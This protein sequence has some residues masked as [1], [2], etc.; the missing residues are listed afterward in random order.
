MWIFAIVLGIILYIPI[1]VALG[2]LLFRRIMKEREEDGGEVV[3]ENENFLWKKFFVWS[4]VRNK[5]DK[6]NF[7]E[8]FFDAGRGNV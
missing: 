3:N 7:F 5:R 1:G 6:K 8:K 4:F 2:I